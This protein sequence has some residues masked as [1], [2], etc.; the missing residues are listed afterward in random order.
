MATVLKALRRWISSP[1]AAATL[2]AVWPGLGHL[3]HKTGRALALLIPTLVVAVAGVVYAVSRDKTTLFA[4]GV[5]RPSLWILIAGALCVLAFRVA[6]AVD[7]YRTATEALQHQSSRRSVVRRLAIFI[8]FAV[9]IAAPHVIVIRYAVA[10]LVFLSDVFDSTNTQTAKA[11]PITVDAITVSTLPASAAPVEIPTSS[12]SIPQTTSVPSTVT[13]PTTSTS[14]S[15]TVAPPTTTTL[16]TWD[17]SDRL[18]VALLGSDGGF[19]RSGVRTDTIIVLSIDVATGDAAVFNIPRNWKHLTFPAGTLA[20]E[21]WP[22]GYPG[23]A[24]AVYSLGLIFP[25]VFPDVDDTAGHA[26]KL[27]LAQLTGLD[28]QYYVL[29]DMMGFVDIIDLFGGVHVHVTEYINDRIK[30]IVSG[31][32]SIDIV[33][34]PGDYHFDGLT[35]LG[36]VR[37]RTQ[38]SDYHRMT[39][40]RCV[41]GAL[42]DQVTPISVLI[43]YRSLTDIISAHVIT[44]IPLDRLDELIAIGDKLNISRIVTV[45]FIP[46]EYPSG[47][48]PIVKVRDAVSQAFQGTTN[49]DNRALADACQR[50]R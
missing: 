9:I 35:A 1:L 11:T 17:G 24:N 44:D 41:V 4:W 6:V 12:V 21:R 19:D 13:P 22:D 18:T 45:N 42:I 7:A 25:E 49:E 16:L 36:Y 10:Q 34:K 31:E 30:P 38:T 8:P 43:N 5:S 27:A 3:R 47:D 48:A 29:M 32:P 37:A 50:T 39:R 28:I 33:V 46:P 40:Q 15:T 26:I 14:T 20:S 2:S 23:I